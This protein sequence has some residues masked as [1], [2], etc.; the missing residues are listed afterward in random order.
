M[1]DKK[2]ENGQMRMLDWI[3]LGWGLREGEGEPSVRSQATKE[4]AKE[5]RESFRERERVGGEQDKKN[6]IYILISFRFP[7]NVL[8][9]YLL[10]CL[11]AP[12]QFS[13]RNSR[14]EVK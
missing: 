7:P 11:F 13:S 1:S 4:R 12:W 10:V 6:M 2:I 5:A 9:C 14:I 8:E 3:G